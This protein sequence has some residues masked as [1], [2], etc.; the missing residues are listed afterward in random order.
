MSEP[1]RDE[2]CYEINDDIGY[3]DEIDE[4]KSDVQMEVSYYLTPKGQKYVKE[5]IIHKLT[6]DQIDLLIKFKCKINELPLDAI[7][8]YVYNKY[9]NSAEKSKIKEKYLKA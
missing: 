9:P 5:N 1:E 7:L 8:E 3:G 2:F 4:C 6:A